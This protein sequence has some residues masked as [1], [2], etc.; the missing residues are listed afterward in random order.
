MAPEYTRVLSSARM[1]FA[2]PESLRPKLDAIRQF[3]AEQVIPIEP[4]LLGSHDF[5]AAEQRMLEVREHAKARGLWLPQVA[6][7]HGG[8]GLSLLEHGLVSEVLGQ[9]PLGH[10]ALNCQAPDAGNMEI[11]AEYGSRAQREH[12]LE[13]LLKGT[14]RSCFAMTEPDKAGS[15]P[16]WLGTT[17]RREGDDY[18]IDGHKWFTTGADG[19]AFAIVM[20]VTEPE[21]P[22]HK[23][24]SMLIVPTNTHGFKL[25]RNIPIMGEAGSGWAS[26]GEVRFDGCRVP[27]SNMLGF[28]GAGFLIAQARLGPGRIHHCMRWIGICER[29]FTMMCTRAATRE[30]AP[31]RWLGQEQTIQNWIAESRAEIDSARWMV[32]HAAWRIDAVGQKDAR[33]D[34]SLI[35]FHVA[36][37]LRDVLERAIQVHGALGITDDTVLSFF[38]RHERGARI[39]DG[40]D[41]VHKSVVAR[42]I[43]QDFGL[44]TRRKGE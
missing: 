39:Y 5:R 1:D 15:N 35:K 26:H 3:V 4:E 28:P 2:I 29:A 33:I 37:V 23:R 6:A 27:A 19:A 40:P 11:L 31:G 30:L 43:L 9:S 34:V 25:V 44:D 14:I 22:A 7:R 21:Q 32:L 12:W 10:Y 38:Y 42:R 20:A 17:A 8:M 16:V 41:E 24:A 36:K 13:P 18:V